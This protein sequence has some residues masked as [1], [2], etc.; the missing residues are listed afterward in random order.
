MGITSYLPPVPSIALGTPDISLFEMVG[1]YS[2][3]VN[4]GIYV[5]PVMIS[6][7][8][9]KNGRAIYEV[10]PETKDDLSEEAAFPFFNSG[11]VL[12]HHLDR[13]TPETPN[14]RFP[15]VLSEDINNILSIIDIKY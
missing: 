12:E 8:E 2:T 3:F 4:K 14:A 1:A 7:I 15:R 11:K 5:K 6:R 10:V 13:W 9:D